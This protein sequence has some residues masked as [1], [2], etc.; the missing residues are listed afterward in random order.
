[1]SDVNLH[2]IAERVASVV[3]KKLAE[4][5]RRVSQI[6][7]KI[8]RLELDVNSIRTQTIESIM[9]SVLSIKIDD[10]ANAF[11]AR[12]TRELSSVVST[13]QV[14]VERIDG[15]VKK[16]DEVVNAFSGLKKSVDD[17]KSV[18]EQPLNID[19][20]IISGAVEE[21]IGKH[22]ESFEDLQK[23]LVALEEKANM[24]SSKVDELNRIGNV[25]SSLTGIADRVEELK[26]TIAEIKDAVDYIKEVSE[27]I[28]E[29]L[30][31]S[32]GEEEEE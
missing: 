8:S 24:L 27:I 9:R 3:N 14:V 31:K 5:D 1:M 12:M 28:E 20:S 19:K 32:G 18:V 13:I 25:V 4:F 21:V 23:R 15:A 2:I 29:S 26:K 22:L 6:E 11:T 30:K 17:V 16:L 10:I 7:D